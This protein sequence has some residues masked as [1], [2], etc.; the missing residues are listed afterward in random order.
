MR[1]Y[2]WYTTVSTVCQFQ[3]YDCYYWILLKEVVGI[4]NRLHDVSIYKKPKLHI[5]NGV[6]QYNYI[7]QATKNLST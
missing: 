4:T 7:T 3:F 5:L 2:M 6:L 1:G